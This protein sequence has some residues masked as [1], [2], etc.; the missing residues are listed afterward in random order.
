[1]KI[2]IIILAVLLALYIAG[3]LL[4]PVGASWYIE[5]EIKKRCPDATDVSVSVRAFPAFKLFSKKY[6]KLTIE[7]KEIKLEGIDFDSIK[8]SSSA[9]PSGT[10]DAVI[11]QGEINDFFS[12]ADSYLEN[13]QVTIQDSEILVTGTLDLG[14]GPLNVSGTGTLVSRNGR[15]VFIVP[16]NITVGG[17]SVPGEYEAAVRQYIS[18]SPI[19]TVREDLPFTITAIKAGHGKLTITG[20]VDIEEALKFK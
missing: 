12:V 20:D 15:E 19:F 18:D 10:F 8:L 2:L 11:G 3:E 16:D 1:M 4:I 6:S 13:P 17:G 5:R 14:F 9:Y 7:A